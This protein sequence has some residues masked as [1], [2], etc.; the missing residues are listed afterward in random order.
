MPLHHDARIVL[1]SPSQKQIHVEISY[2]AVTQ[3]VIGTL[4]Y[5]YAAFHSE[6]KT[7]GYRQYQVAH[8]KGSGLFICLNL[9]DPGHNHGG[10]DAALIDGSS[11]QP[12][13]LHGLRGKTILV[14]HCITYAR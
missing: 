4:P 11:N 2:A 14:L 13:V 10:G 5:F 6:Q 7:E 8:I 12:H 9:F 1:H 3:A